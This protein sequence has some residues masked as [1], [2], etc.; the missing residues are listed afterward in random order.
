MEDNDVAEFHLTAVH[1][2]IQQI[3]EITVTGDEHNGRLL[4]IPHA[5]HHEQTD[6]RQHSFINVLL[7]VDRVN[8][9]APDAELISLLCASIVGRYLE[10]AYKIRF[11]TVF[12]ESA[13]MRDRFDF[14]I[15]LAEV[16]SIPVGVA[17]VEIPERPS[18]CR[19]SQRG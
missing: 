5:L 18:P 16:V 12:G 1:Q 9:E 17:V 3:A 10:F 19:N 2:L 6:I 14:L 8:V 7:L 4:A 15:H 13:C 11:E